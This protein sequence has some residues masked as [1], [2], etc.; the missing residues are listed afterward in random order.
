MGVSNMWTRVGSMMAPLVKI[1][2]EV[3]PFIPNV[4]FGTAA[5]VGGSAALFL[6]ETRN[7]PLPETIEDL[8]SWSVPLLLS[9]SVLLLGPGPGLFLSS[10]SVGSCP[11]R[12]QSRRWKQKRHPR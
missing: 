3:K 10:L 8:E 11:K 12:S 5:I 1:T 4:I 7:R 6:P 2:G 9:P